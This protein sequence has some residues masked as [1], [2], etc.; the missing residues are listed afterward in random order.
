M[1]RQVIRSV[2]TEKAYL[3]LLPGTPH[4]VRLR[5]EETLVVGNTDLFDLLVGNRQ[6]KA[7]ADS[8]SQYPT[9]HLTFTPNVLEAP[10]YALRV[11]MAKGPLSPFGVA[12]R[13]ATFVSSGVRPENIKHSLMHGGGK[14]HG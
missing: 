5:L 6:M 8:L 7:I 3:H 9:A 13:R 10:S 14:D 12:K 4:Q 2:A 1:G 11:P